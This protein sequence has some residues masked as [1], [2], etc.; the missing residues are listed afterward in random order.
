[1][2]VTKQ[3]RNETDKKLNITTQVITQDLRGKTL[4]ECQGNIHGARDWNLYSINK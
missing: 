1:M 3:E 4:T 2:E